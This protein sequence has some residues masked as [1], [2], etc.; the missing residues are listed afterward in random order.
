MR[1]S[2]G[3]ENSLA[4]LG[5]ALYIFSIGY[6]ATDSVLFF[7]AYSEYQ[8]V[9]ELRRKLPDSFTDAA[10]LSKAPLALIRTMSIAT[11]AFLCGVCCTVVAR[12]IQAAQDDPA[13]PVDE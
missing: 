2:I 11:V 3:F 13:H 9:D 1:A 12:K 6:A 5:I 4:I 7:M 10:I 8:Y